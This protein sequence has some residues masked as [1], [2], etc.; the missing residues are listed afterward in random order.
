MPTGNNGYEWPQ[1][2]K[3]NGL[4]LGS[5]SYTP[6]QLLAIFGQPSQGNGLT[7]LA[8]QLIA[9]KLNVANGASSNFMIN[10]KT[11]SQAIAEADALIGSLVVPPVGNGSL[12][13]NL[14]SALNEI[15]TTFNEGTTEVPHCN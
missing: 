2:V 12:A 14:V 9:A 7:I 3:D 10:G 13:P 6:Q 11:V 8:H 5:V 1:S 4:V 15:L